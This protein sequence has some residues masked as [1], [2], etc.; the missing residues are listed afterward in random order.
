MPWV[1]ESRSNR[2]PTPRVGT[3]RQGRPSRRNSV[4]TPSLSVVVPLYNSQSVVARLTE[5]LLEVMP[6]LAGDTEII[7]VDDGSTDATVEV[8]QEL[9][10]NF[11]QVLLLVH[12]ATLGAEE[13]LR[14]AMRY[15]RGETLLACRDAGDLDPHELHKLWSS[16][17]ADVAVAG[18]WQSGAPLGSIPRAPAL[19]GKPAPQPFP[20]VLLV[21]RRLLVGWR[22]S[23][24]HDNLFG[25]LKSRGYLLPS[26]TLRPRRQRRA[27]AALVNL[28][29]RRYSEQSAAGGTAP[30]RDV[31]VSTYSVTDAHAARPRSPK[32]LMSRLRAFAWGE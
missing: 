4:L 22:Q 13:S 9:S 31:A 6:E 10:L 32:H 28:L 14:S 2:A 12:P 3:H 18:Y 8:A 20:D 29:E 19:A 16:L 7:L 30:R 21:P 5:E 26:V 23:G 27:P 17:A 15:A 24:G 25:Y 1:V 11:P